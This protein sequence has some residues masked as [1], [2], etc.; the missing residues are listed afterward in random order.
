MV[1]HVFLT[2]KKRIG[3]STMIHKILNRCAG[4][5]GGFLT[6]KTNEFLKDS[7]S[8]HLFRFDQEKIPNEQNLLFVCGKSND[9]ISERFDRLGCEA[10][11]GCSGHSLIVMDELGP[12]EASAVLFHETV[13]KLLNGSVP[14]LGVLQAPAELFWPEITGH[15]MVELIEVSE[16]N[17]DKEDMIL[18]AAEILTVRIMFLRNAQ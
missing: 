17:R 11:C 8:V 5:V 16:H 15:P 4:D 10:L 3:K 2:G 1:R 7:Y 6:V 9:R 18:H 13:L 12:H 14:V